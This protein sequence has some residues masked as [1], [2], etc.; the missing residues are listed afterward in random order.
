MCQVVHLQLRNHLRV[1]MH[2]RQQI[3][4]WRHVVEIPVLR[5]HVVAMD[6]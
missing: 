5:Q 2:V 4:R 1:R 6:V 3:A